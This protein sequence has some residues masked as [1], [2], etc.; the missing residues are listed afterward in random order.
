M[1]CPQCK[2]EVLKIR[3][4]FKDGKEYEG[5]VGCTYKSITPLFMSGVTYDGKKVLTVAHADDIKHRKV[6]PS[7]GAVYRDYKRTYFT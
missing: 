6:D 3:T 1:I 4:I 2:Q 5:C 7:T